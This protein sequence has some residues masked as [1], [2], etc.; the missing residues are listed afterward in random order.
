MAPAKKYDY[1][2]IIPDLD[3]RP[4]AQ[5]PPDRAA[6]ETELPVFSRLRNPGTETLFHLG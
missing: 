2:P 4:D 5:A 6:I 3:R 1:L